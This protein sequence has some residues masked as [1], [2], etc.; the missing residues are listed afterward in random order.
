MS[1]LYDTL[2]VPKSA[3]AEEIKLAYRKLARDSHPDANPEDSGAEER[4]KEISHAYDVLGDSEKRAAYDAQQANPFGRAG[5]GTTAGG[6]GGFGGAGFD[7]SD[8]FDAFGDRFGGA[9]TKPGGQRTSGDDISVD[10]RISFDQAMRGAQVA[11]KVD[12]RETCDQC[13]GTGAKP[14]S[15][16]LCVMSAAVAAPSVGARSVPGA[17]TLS[18]LCRPRARDRRSVSDPVKASAANRSASATT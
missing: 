8:L 5:G 14:G 15:D 13:R 7:M 4:F 16:T 2:G 6:P 1:T 17:A 12:K 10:V 11:V 3:T 18:S 9:A